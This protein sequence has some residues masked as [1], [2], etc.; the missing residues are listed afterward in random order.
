MNVLIAQFL[1]LSV[2]YSYSFWH[3]FSNAVIIQYVC[4]IPNSS[5]KSED[6][7]SISQHVSFVF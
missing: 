7:H 3:M 5:P 4:V 6:L 1:L 2:T